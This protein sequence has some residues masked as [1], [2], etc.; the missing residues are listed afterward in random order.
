MI[1]TLVIQTVSCWSAN[2]FNKQQ[3]RQD[4]ANASRVLAEYS[5]LREELLVNASGVLAADF[6]FKTAVATCEA[7]TIQ[8]VLENHGQRINADLMLIADLDGQ[9]IANSQQKIISAE[10][11]QQLVSE[12]L[13]L[14]GQAQIVLLDNQLYQLI[15]QPIKTPRTIAYNLAGFEINQQTLQKL[16][17]LTGL[18]IS[19][20]VDNKPV[21]SSLSQ[22]RSDD[23]VIKQLDTHVTTWMS[24]KRPTFINLRSA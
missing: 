22:M 10:A 1:T 11:L 6:G 20:L 7:D 16:T 24:L 19:F 18:E 4:V 5:A 12:L 15:L 8:S 17:D 13:L 23:A 2:A 9:L 3:K 14:E 21:L